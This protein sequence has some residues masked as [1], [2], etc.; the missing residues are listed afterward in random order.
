MREDLGMALITGQI[1][2][3][4]YRIVKRIAE[5][6]MARCIGHGFKSEYALCIERKSGYS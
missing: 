5:A 1:L 6:D 4:R 2:N 3:G